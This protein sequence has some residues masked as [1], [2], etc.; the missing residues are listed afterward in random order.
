MKTLLTVG[1]LWFLP[2]GSEKV[3]YDQ[4]SRD[5]SSRALQKPNH[6]SVNIN[7][8][9]T[10]SSQAIDPSITHRFLII[11]GR[12]KPECSRDNYSLTLLQ[13]QCNENVLLSYR[14][15]LCESHDVYFFYIYIYIT[16]LSVHV[17]T[18]V[19]PF[20]FAMNSQY[21]QQALLLLS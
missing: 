8:V 1:G 7:N 12:E 11:E 13:H 18:L 16:S 5:R 10:A 2:D 19:P 14:F 20:S 6:T 15:C 21:Q 17:F 4:I 9:K 3:T